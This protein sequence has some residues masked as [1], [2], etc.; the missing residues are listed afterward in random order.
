MKKKIGLI[1]GLAISGACL[2]W[3]FKDVD[4]RQFGTAL[5]AID[6]PWLCASLAIFYWSM[7]L[8]GVRWALLFRPRHELRGPRMFPPIMIGFAFNSIM[9]GRV[10]EFAR[11]FYLDKRESTGFAA[12]MA[13]V[14]TERIFD[15][16]TLLACLAISLAMLPPI[17]PA[18]EVAF[19]KFVV[20]GD[21]LQPLT[22]KVI[23]GCVVLIV[24]VV[25]LLIP[26]ADRLVE[27]IIR[28]FPGIPVKLKE[29]LVGISRDVIGG[30]SS[31]KDPLNLAKVVGYSILI[32][33][34]VAFSNLTLAWGVTGI[35]Q[36]S[37]LQ[38]MALVTMIAIFIMIP[39]APGY[40][41]LFEAGVIFGLKVLKV[42]E[43]VAP[44]TAYAIVMH[45]VQ[46]VPIVAI[47]LY[48]AARSPVNLAEAKGQQSPTL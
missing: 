42:Q 48:C 10:G 44:A 16:V 9:P 20:K 19:G 24:G 4:I 29:K 39:A 34:L 35:E 18:V 45:L 43:D 25:S 1:L 12:S 5:K 30:F 6:I 32:W 27:K 7:Y 28:A 37:F 17:D 11:A 14:V 31:V 2:Y 15:G 23:I 26:G 13:T 22:N 33:L 38:C 47:G 36:I 46:F 41:G 8:R 40:W 21:M 3:V